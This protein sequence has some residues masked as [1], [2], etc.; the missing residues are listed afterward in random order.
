MPKG[1]ICHCC[2][3]NL[4]VFPVYVNMREVVSTLLPTTYGG[5]SHEEAYLHSSFVV[6]YFV[7][8]FW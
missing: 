7:F 3:C 2:G 1:G 6:F 4:L 5:K 8:V